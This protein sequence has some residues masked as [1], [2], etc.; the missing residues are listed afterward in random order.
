[1]DVYS[2]RLE[3]ETEPF[4]VEGESPSADECNS[5]GRCSV[6][7]LPPNLPERSPVDVLFQYAPNGRLK[8]KVTV[9][10]TDTK[11]ETEFTRENSLSKEHL[12]G[13]RK[14]ITGLDPT[15]HV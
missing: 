11:V 2:A 4:V 14:Y 10:N 7:R 8:V 9:P 13:W 15:D 1:M 5:I 6:R 3:D 12:N